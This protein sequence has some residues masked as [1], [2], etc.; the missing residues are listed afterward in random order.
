M[1]LRLSS[2]FLSVFTSVLRPQEGWSWLGL[3][4]L[5][6]H[7]AQA[8]SRAI[9]SW[10]C[11]SRDTARAGG[12]KRDDCWH[13]PLCF[14]VCLC[15]CLM[16]PGSHSLPA[17]SVPTSCCGDGGGAASR[18]G[19]AGWEP[20]GMRWHRGPRALPAA[21]HRGVIA[22]TSWVWYCPLALPEDSGVSRTWCHLPAHTGPAVPPCEGACDPR[23]SQPTPGSSSPAAPPRRQPQPWCWGP[24]E[25]EGQLWAVLLVLAGHGACPASLGWLWAS[26]TGDQCHLQRHSRGLG[27]P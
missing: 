2:Y 24:H 17:R 8:T 23:C 26:G 21:P 9:M 15:W 3:L 11:G 12:T 10:Q 22:S 7:T 14:A 19:A 5:P 27:W 1:I 20:K 16:C 6:T 25:A 4:W 13:P 18:A